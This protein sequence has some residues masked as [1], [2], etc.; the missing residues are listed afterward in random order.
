MTQAGCLNLQSIRERTARHRTSV[1]EPGPARQFSAFCCTQ[2][3]E[4]HLLTGQ[5]CSY[6]SRTGRYRMNHGD[7]HFVAAGRA[8]P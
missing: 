2:F 1:I 5:S 8:A 6:P 3:C 4:N 7:S